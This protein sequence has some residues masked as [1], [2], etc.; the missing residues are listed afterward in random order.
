M[1]SLAGVARNM[2]APT[3]SLGSYAPEVARPCVGEA[4]YWLSE[5]RTC[6]SLK[7]LLGDTA[8]TATL[9]RP[10]SRAI[11]PLALGGPICNSWRIQ[12]ATRL[13]L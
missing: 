11:A 9:Q 5:L 4:R 1:K 13:S 3:K 8:L 12:C 6:V 7:V 2:R 10:T